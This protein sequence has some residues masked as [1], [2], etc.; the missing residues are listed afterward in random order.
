M[1]SLLRQ[2]SRSTKLLFFPHSCET[3]TCYRRHIKKLDQFHLRSLRKIPKI[4]WKDRMPNQEVLRKA[5]MPG[6]EALLLKAQLRW[7]GHVLRKDGSRL[8][9]QLLY[10]ELSLG[11]RHQ[12]GQ[13]KRFKDTL[14]K[15]LRSCNIPIDS[16]EELIQDRTSWRKAVTDG[17]K[18]FESTRLRTLDEKRQARK[19]RSAIIDPASSV[20]CP[21]CRRICASAFGL[22]AHQRRH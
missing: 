10:S 4:S 17:V 15:T 11:R 21:T 6:I 13:L 5:N 14:K 16:W 3:W 20:S 1:A 2:N 7:T 18:A 8:P 12:G 9:K 19:S 22:R